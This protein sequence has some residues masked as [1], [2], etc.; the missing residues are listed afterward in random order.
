MSAADAKA[1]NSVLSSSHVGPQISG[2]PPQT[3]MG[4]PTKYEQFFLVNLFPELVARLQIRIDPCV[5]WPPGKPLPDPQ[6]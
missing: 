1:I 2:F 4:I 3:K 5:A 6:L